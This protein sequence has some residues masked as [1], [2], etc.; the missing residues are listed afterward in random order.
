MY[1]NLY[2]TTN[3]IILTLQSENLNHTG[4]NL[5]VLQLNIRSV[6]KHSYKLKSLLRTL[7][8]KNSRVDLVLLCET[9]LT[10]ETVRLVHIPDYT[11]VSNQR[12]KSKGGGT[13]ILIRNGT[14]Y[15]QD[16]EIFDEGKIESTFIE[17]LSKNGEKIFIGSMYQP[18]NTDAESFNIKLNT[19]TSKI[20][21]SNDKEVIIG[22]DHNLDLLKCST[23]KHTQQFIDEMTD[24][25]LLP[26]ITRP[27]HITHS[28]TTLLDNIFVSEKLHRFYES[29]LYW[30]ICLITYPR[31][32]S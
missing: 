13:A 24:K 12:S 2:G 8:S 10:P 1:M 11:L 23:H 22:I 16:L 6:L 25:N 4:F 20:A 14:C 28:S 9:F 18:P 31:W 27:T 21:M 19:I 26:T 15:K 3:V 7:E 29:G 30:M 32:P 17:V 5:T